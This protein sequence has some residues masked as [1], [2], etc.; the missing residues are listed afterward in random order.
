[1]IKYLDG[2]G[3]PLQLVAKEASLV[4]ST[5]VKK[6]IVVSRC[7][8]MITGIKVFSICLMCLLLPMEHLKNN[9]F[10]EQATF[11]SGQ[12]GGQGE[13]FFYGQTTYEKSPLNRVLESAAP[14][15]NFSGSMHLAESSRHSTKVKYWLNTL[16][17]NVQAG[18]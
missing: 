9:P 13:T 16:T 2:L 4:T 11:M 10:S 12:Y 3:R 8:M 5:A 18:Q 17:D 14:G 6:D 7:N 1:M 15:N